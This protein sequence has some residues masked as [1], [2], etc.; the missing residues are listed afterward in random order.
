MALIK[1]ENWLI[2]QAKYD[3]IA[4]I[5]SR[6]HEVTPEALSQYLADS[7]SRELVQATGRVAV[8]NVTGPMIR[9]GGMFSAMSGITTTEDIGAAFVTLDKSGDY[10]RIILSFDSPGGTVNGLYELGELIGRASKPV[11]AYV[12]GECCSAAYWLA[13]KCDSITASRTSII[14]CIGT[15]SGRPDP[16]DGKSMVS[17][18]APAKMGSEQATQAVLNALE[19]EFISVVAEGRGVSEQTVIDTFGGGG[20]FVGAAAIEPGL[21]DAVGTLD[22]LIAGA[23]GIQSARNGVTTA[24]K[25]N[26][27]MAKEDG[28]TDGAEA[29]AKAIKD[30]RAEGVT[31]GKLE[32]EA[33]VQAAVTAECTRV[34][35]VFEAGKGK[36]F[37][38]VKALAT[39]PTQ[40]AES[41][42]EALADVADQAASSALATTMASTNPV[43]TGGSAVTT[44]T[45]KGQASRDAD[46]AAG[47]DSVFGKAS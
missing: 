2:T 16:D 21:I 27:S 44:D 8:I 14:G 35:G 1:S 45:D 30:A 25:G 24:T 43:I 5:A 18:H 23:A 4:E 22:D 32:A 37:S 36:P 3:A 28:G 47:L 7:D 31:A 46:I 26:T 9:Y 15:R 34:C 33:T 12:T 13:C 29:T 42:T 39:N 6:S 38:F 17:Q 19:A 41:A 40:T 10:D 11:D 20:V